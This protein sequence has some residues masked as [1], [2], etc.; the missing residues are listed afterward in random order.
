MS[1]TTSRAWLSAEGKSPPVTKLA[2]ANYFAA[3]ADMIAGLDRG[4]LVT[5][6][7]GNV[8][9]VSGD[10]SGSVKGGRI[11]RHGRLAE[12]LCGTMIAG[13]AFDLLPGIVAVSRE[14][15]RMPG[16]VIGHVLLDDVVVSAG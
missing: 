8:D 7:S 3:V 11:I 5:R 15:E 6:F 2:L 1:S 4:L 14:R 16:A 10:F 13:N 12:P 9:P